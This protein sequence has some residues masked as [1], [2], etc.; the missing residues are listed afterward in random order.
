MVTW[1]KLGEL[2]KLEAHKTR[3]EDG[4]LDEISLAALSGV[5]SLLNNIVCYEDTV[6]CYEDNIVENEV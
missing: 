5:P 1:H 3:H 6:V 4:G 2:I